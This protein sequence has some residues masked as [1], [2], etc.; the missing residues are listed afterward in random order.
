MDCQAITRQIALVAC[1]AAA[2]QALTGIAVPATVAADAE[3]QATFQNGNSDSY[4]VYLAASLAGANGPACYLRNSTSLSSPISLTIP[5]SVGPSADYYSIAIAD[6]S[7]GEGATY[8]NHFNFTGGTG[9]YTKYEDQLGG[10]PFWSADAL[11]CSAYACAR[12][13]AQA[14][15]PGDLTDSSAYDTM[16]ACILRC[17]GVTPA[18]NITG[19]AHASSSPSSA[20]G[21]GATQTVSEV[22]LT[23][24]SGAVVTAVETT[25]TISGSAV[26]EAVMGSVTITLGGAEATVSGLAVSML[27]NGIKVA[28]TTTAAFSSAEQTL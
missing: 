20:S 18:P 17:P 7:T 25:A 11:P 21:A 14:G 3:F 2:A 12:Q 16:Q 15:Y 9:N 28:G 8:S 24:G 13:C 5:A 19:P 22:V 6:L 23:L 1:L 4:R 10:A 26:T 27:S